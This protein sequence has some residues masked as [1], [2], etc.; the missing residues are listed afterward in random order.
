MI[1]KMSMFTLAISF[2]HFQ[3]TLIHGPNILASYTLLFFTASNF[4][5]TTRHIDNWISFPLWPSHFFLSGAISN[6]PPLFPSSILDTFWHEGGGR[7]L[8]FRCHIFL[9]FHTVYVNGFLTARTLEW[10]AIPSS[11]G[12]HFVRTLY[13][14]PSVLGDPAQHGSELHWIMQAPSAWLGC[15]PWRLGI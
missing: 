8:I 14:D 4:T 1:P 15:D 10:F 9:S 2:N 6:C 5:F 3:F 11:S 7:T 13:Y 12:P